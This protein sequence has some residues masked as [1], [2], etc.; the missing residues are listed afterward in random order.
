MNEGRGIAFP[1]QEETVELQSRKL[2]SL[3]VAAVTALGLVACGGDAPPPPPEPKAYERAL[4]A[5]N[6][7]ETE[8]AAQAA[9]D[10]V[11][12]KAI[13]G[14]QAA[15]LMTALG[16]RKAAL[17]EMARIEAQKAA[18]KAAADAIDTSGLSDADAVAAARNA[19]NG[20]KAALDAAD[21]VSDADK[22]MYRSM[23]DDADAA[24]R[25][26]ET[27]LDT[28]NRMTAQRTAITDALTEAREALRAVN[29]GSTEAEVM[30]AD[31]AVAALG[32]AIDDAA[33]LPEGDL[34]VAR[35]RGSH[36]VLVAWLAAAKE[37]R[38]AALEKARKAE[39]AA[40]AARAAKLYPGIAPQ[41]DDAGPSRRQ[42]SH[43]AGDGILV[44]FGGP[45]G[46]RASLDP[47]EETPVLEN[48]GWQ[49]RRYASLD[50]AGAP[51]GDGFEAVVYSNV[52]GL[53][54]KFGSAMPGTG[55]SRE[56]EYMLADGTLAL[57]TG[58][59]AEP[60]FSASRVRSQRFVNIADVKRF[61][62]RGDETN[63][64]IAGSYYGVSGTYDCTPGAGGACGVRVAAAGFDLGTVAADAFTN[65]G[66]TWTFRPDDPNA[67][68][69][70]AVDSA[71]ASYGWWLHT[72]GRNGQRFGALNA[73][74]FEDEKGG[75]PAASGIDALYGK[76]AYTGGAAG[77]YALSSLTGGTND[78]GSFTARATLEA[79]FTGNT[80][81]GTIDGFAG[82][83]GMARDWSVELTDQAV[84]AG[85]VIAGAGSTARQL[86][87]WTIGGKSVSDSGEWT[88][89]F[90][91]NGDDGVPKVVTGTFYTE[92][93]HEGRMVGGFGATRQQ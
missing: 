68:V 15:Q 26:A 36:G 93:G 28:R 43:E 56:F 58:G 21:D 77:Q 64:L 90:R 55:A 81:S 39:I 3:A 57:V 71:Y 48:H 37:R 40:I 54:R 79:D 25:M 74:A 53:G 27:G 13:T 72:A 60:A 8:A 73:S 41:N 83:D 9:Y 12:G 23:L 91:D 49:G 70:H 19:V 62:L 69:V 88:G 34:T 4:A 65:N 31:A 92:F 78:V 2:K 14:A 24:V 87:R 84:S 33:D 76:A 47:G 11:D 16:N 44:V 29:D 50:A 46:M 30:A 32:M 45:E 22:A 52:E 1:I 17:E 5:I 75:V 82:A 7:A 86:T 38:T 51:P 80:V 42:A 20:L 67:R 6:A 89:T 61:R 10:D 63:V 59:S 66:G 85:G 35:A 18:L